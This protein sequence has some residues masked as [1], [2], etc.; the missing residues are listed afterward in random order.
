MA[1]LIDYPSK[2]QWFE[3]YAPEV[4]DLSWDPT[5]KSSQVEHQ[6]QLASRLAGEIAPLLDEAWLTRE[7]D[8]PIE[9]IGPEAA[10]AL[11]AL[12]YAE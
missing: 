6:P 11:K 8:E 7:P 12:G 2:Y 1:S 5:E 3:R 9:G 10:E 4:Y